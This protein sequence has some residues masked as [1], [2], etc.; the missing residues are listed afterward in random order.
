MRLAEFL[1]LQKRVD[2][3]VVSFLSYPNAKHQIRVRLLRNSADT[4]SQSKPN[5][6]DSMKLDQAQASDKEY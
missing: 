6:L 4:P 3:K 5:I 1:I 2:L